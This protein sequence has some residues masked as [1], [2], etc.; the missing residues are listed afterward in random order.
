MLGAGW[1]REPPGETGYATEAEA[2]AWLELLT[3]EMA[4]E[5]SAPVDVPL[6]ADWDQETND[7]LGALG[8]QYGA[9][10][11]APNDA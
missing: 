3:S 5:P 4:T 6:D 1:L 9:Y 11:V 8:A 10:R 7:I 2:I